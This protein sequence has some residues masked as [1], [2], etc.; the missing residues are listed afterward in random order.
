VERPAYQRSSGH[1]AFV[2]CRPLLV[3]VHTSSSAVDGELLADSSIRREAV[4]ST[5]LLLIVRRERLTCR[6]GDA[7]LRAG[8]EERASGAGDD[9]CDRVAL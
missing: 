3:F 6:L 4:V 8:K 1:F 5:S 2:A 9:A 7:R